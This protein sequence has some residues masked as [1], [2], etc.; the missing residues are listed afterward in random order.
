M[1]VEASRGWLRFFDELEDPRMDRTKRHELD[2]IL[3]ITL[4]AVI[5]GADS[6]YQVELFGNAKLDW[7]QTFLALPNGIPSHDTFGRVF[8]QLDPHQLERCFQRWMAT[9]ASISRGDLVAI[10][11]KTI[12][13][14]FDKAN[15]KA[16]IHMVSAW[17]DTNHM[18][19][20]QLAIGE[21]SNEI[22]A[23]AIHVL[24]QRFRSQNPPYYQ[25]F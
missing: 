16:P 7:L 10:D 18:V 2:D 23:I 3:F 14:S 21:K 24:I 12:R 19:L 17:C 4:C 6:W 9:L 15:D 8:S 25:R 13:H 5:C 20:G 11:G 1:D 22:K